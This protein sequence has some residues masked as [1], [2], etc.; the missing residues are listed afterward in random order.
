[1][2]TSLVNSSLSNITDSH[3]KLIQG[4]FDG[5]FKKKIVAPLRHAFNSG[6]TRTLS[7]RK[8]QLAHLRAFLLEQES[9]IVDALYADLGKPG[10]E[11][12]LTEISATR[13]EIEYTQKRL[14]QWLRPQRVSTAVPNQPGHSFSIA[15]PLGVVLIIAPW[16]YPVHLALAPLVSALAAGNCAIIKPSELA[17]HCATLLAK[18]LPDY[19]DAEAVQ[20]VEGGPDRVENL[21]LEHFDHIFFTGSQ[22]TA[23]RIMAAAAQ[24]LTPITL[25]L[26]GKNPCIVDRSADIQVA[27][28]RIAWGKF[29][30]AGQTCVAPDYLLVDAAFETPLITALKTALQK[31]YGVEP[32]A[33]GDFQRVANG[34]QFDRISALLEDGEVAY[35]GITNPEQLS[36]AP[37][38]LRRVAIDAPIME[39]EIFGPILPILPVPDLDAALG[40]VKDRPKPL[41]L[42]LFSQD[43][44]A[45][46]R[47]IETTSSGGV[48]INDVV[49]Q[50]VGPQ[51][52]FG[53]VGASGMGAY[54]GRTGFETFS[55]RKS[56]LVKTTRL[57][58]PLRYPPYGRF[59]QRWL[60]RLT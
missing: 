20:V 5:P 51:L 48:C 43:K 32:M 33:S 34:H 23:R 52:P 45:H 9:A 46:R 41:A 18:R 60:R 27:A 39:E 7:W 6:R 22:A 47:V 35:G 13:M 25:E 37:T 15:E 12:W 58:L 44:A 38:L 8:T 31:F 57:E 2:E 26:G 53:G 56:V 3:T 30:N 1:M 49:M 29:L 17:S 54:H 50:L 24:H 28:R 42:Y 16:N 11:A 10:F 36:I 4:Y 21:L 19:L 55:H 40:F 14:K 59:Y